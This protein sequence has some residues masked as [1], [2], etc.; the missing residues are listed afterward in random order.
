[1]GHLGYPGASRV[2]EPGVSPRFGSA[3]MT[4]ALGRGRGC[5]G[6][7]RVASSVGLGRV[8]P[9]FDEPLL[10]LLLLGRGGRNRRRG[11]RSGTSGFLELRGAGRRARRWR[12]VTVHRRGRRGRGRRPARRRRGRGHPLDSYQT[13]RVLQEVLHQLVAAQLRLDLLRRAVP[14][15]WVNLE[16]PKKFSL[17]KIVRT[18]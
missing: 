8:G 4:G 9:G 2:L 15:V 10:L 12:G 17:E 11:W 6:L 7:T 18:F 5:G 13:L 3:P 1:M 14:G 16:L